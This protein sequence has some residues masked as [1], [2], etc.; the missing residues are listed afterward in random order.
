MAQSKRNRN[1]NNGSFQPRRHQNT[2]N[3]TVGGNKNNNPSGNTQQTT[4]WGRTYQNADS[5]LTGKP[6]KRTFF[7]QLINS[8]DNELLSRRAGLISNST[9]REIKKRVDALLEE[10]DKLELQILKLEDFGKTNTTSLTIGEDFNAESWVSDIFA[11]DSR[12]MEIEMDLDIYSR[13][14]GKYFD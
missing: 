9:E 11:I 1:R 7:D 13:M 4:D 14:Y 3:E 6:K 10:K 2:S 12:L 5:V 8:S